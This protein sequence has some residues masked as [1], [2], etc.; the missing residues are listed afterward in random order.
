M[1]GMFVSCSKAGECG[2]ILNQDQSTWAQRIAPLLVS[3]D[4]RDEFARL[5][6]RRIERHYSFAHRVNA[7]MAIYDRLLKV[8]PEPMRHAA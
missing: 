6:R 8:V 1:W 7:E 4:R 3:R 2:V 5:G